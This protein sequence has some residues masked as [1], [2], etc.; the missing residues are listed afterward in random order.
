[1]AIDINTITIRNHIVFALVMRRKKLAIKCLERILNKKIADL[2]YIE[3]EK[4]VE[5]S[6]QVHGVRL[7]VYCE[8]EES[9]YN[10]ELQAYQTEDIP[11]RSRYYQDMMD[12]ILLE[13]SDEYET[14]KKNIVIFICTFDP[15]K[16]GRHIY[17][18]ENRCV[19]DTELRLNDETT[20]IILNTKGKKDDIPKPLKCF[21]DYIETGETIDEYTKEL[22]GAVKEVR[23]DKKWR[24]TILTEEMVLR[25]C[26]K[27]AMENGY[28]K[29]L[30]EGHAKGLEEGH[31]K[32]LEE[33]HAKGLE[34]GHA[35]GLEEGHAKGL[36]EGADN[37]RKETALRML[38]A[39]LAVDMIRIATGYT[40]EE[41]L[42]L[43]KENV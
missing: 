24:K 36:E 19:Q 9:V 11:K 7:D 23:T 26:A 20:K 1:M 30:E 8:N 18:F 15:F 22:D 37:N 14:L 12:M 27:V 5:V 43:A 6:A 32:G 21:L 29:G 39:N 17:T 42:A 41:I 3:S 10:I 31:A 4:T 16:Q 25:D 33:G 2:Q 13:K 35:K 34:E 40:E 28:A 38:K